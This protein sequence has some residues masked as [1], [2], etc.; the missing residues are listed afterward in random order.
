MRTG[1]QIDEGRAME[2]RTALKALLSFLGATTLLSFAYPLARFFVP[3]EDETGA[4]GLTLSKAEILP[5][6]AKDVVLN[7]T[8]V[9]IINRPGK[10]FIALSKVCTHLGCLVNYD[11]GEKRLICPCHA[12]IYDLDGNVVSGPPP[13]PLPRIPLRIEGEDIV[14][15]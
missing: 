6:E 4:K 13:K 9:V 14:I 1:S 2:R 3:S 10:G 8:P 11:R 7:S 12:G 5:G 15:G